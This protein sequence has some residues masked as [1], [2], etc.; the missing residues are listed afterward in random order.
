MYAIT[1]ITGKVGGEVARAL[2]KAGL[3][4]RAV[5]RDSRKGATW[6]DRG[7]DVSLADMNDAAALTDAFKSARAVFVLLPPSLI[8]HQDSL[9][10]EQPLTPCDAPCK[11]HVPKRSSAFQR[12]ARRQ[13]RRTC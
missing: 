4:V 7:C 12:S 2:L 1:G 6:G 8:P 9:R 13:S 5:V 3:P 10:H 11:G